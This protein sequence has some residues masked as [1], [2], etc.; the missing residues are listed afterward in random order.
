MQGF[1][2]KLSAQ[3]VI[4][5]QTIAKNTDVFRTKDG[6]DIA[7]PK[8]T[9]TTG[10]REKGDDGTYTYTYANAKNDYVQHFIDLNGFQNKPNASGIDQFRFLVDANTG[11]VIGY[12][13]KMFMSRIRGQGYDDET[14]ENGN[15]DST[16]IK[17]PSYCGAS[18]LDNGG[19]IIY[20][21]E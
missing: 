16:G 15:C 19:K 18:I 17:Q 5:D 2:E 13:G 9:Y 10:T 6:I 4:D 14:W 12:Y 8:S 1:S 20:S 11:E 7:I 3:T 21:W